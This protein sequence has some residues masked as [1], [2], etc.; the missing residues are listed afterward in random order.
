[1]NRRERRHQR[2]MQ[3]REHKHQLRLM[4]KGGKGVAVSSS[5]TETSSGNHNLIR[6]SRGCCLLIC[7]IGLS[8]CL[9]PFAFL[10]GLF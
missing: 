10:L 8:L 6:K 1:M 3:K 7:L 9:S 4:R 5:E 2:R